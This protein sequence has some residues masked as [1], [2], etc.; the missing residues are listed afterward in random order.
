MDTIKNNGPNSHIVF[1]FAG[2]GGLK[3]NIFSFRGGPKTFSKSPQVSLRDSNSL[4]FLSILNIIA[5]I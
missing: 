4:I 1:F 5:F 2:E 3:K